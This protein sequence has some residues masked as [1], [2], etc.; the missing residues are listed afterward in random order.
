MGLLVDFEYSIFCL[1]VLAIFMIRYIVPMKGYLV[2]M[3]MY[4][5]S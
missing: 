4:V 1:S 2:G 3:I 5:C